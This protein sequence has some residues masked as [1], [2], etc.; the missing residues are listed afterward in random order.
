MY[1]YLILGKEHECPCG[2]P[3]RLVEC[4]VG[5]YVRCPACDNGT[6]MCSTKESAISMWEE[7]IKHRLE[8]L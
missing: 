8:E 2:N 1:G 3:V 6:C 4:G 7:K 5:V